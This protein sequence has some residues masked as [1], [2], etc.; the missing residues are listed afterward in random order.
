MISSA[1]HF[2]YGAV[3]RCY[4]SDSHDGGTIHFIVFRISFVCSSNGLVQII[5]DRQFL[6]CRECVMRHHSTASHRPRAPLSL[7]IL[8]CISLRPIKPVQMMRFCLF[9]TEWARE[10]RANFCSRCIWYANVTR[11]NVINLH[12]RFSEKIVVFES[13]TVCAVCTAYTT[14]VTTI[15]IVRHANIWKW[16]Q[17]F[18]IDERQ[19][20]RTPCAMRTQYV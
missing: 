4:S 11:N 13:S 12:M 17:R 5:F 8:L 19:R 14:M 20:T 2:H 18:V 15:W 10:K 7:F 16:N 3:T 1:I 9:T 6:C